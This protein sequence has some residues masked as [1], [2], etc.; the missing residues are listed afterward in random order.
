MN[1]RTPIWAFIAVVIGFILLAVLITPHHT[2]EQALSIP[3]SVV[4]IEN[5]VFPGSSVYGYVNED[6]ELIEFPTCSAAFLGVSYS[7]ESE[8]GDYLFEWVENSKGGGVI[9]ASLT[10]RGTK[11]ALRCNADGAVFLLYM[12]VCIPQK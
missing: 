7:C 3:N 5:G 11:I 8:N 10:V 4:E 12:A 1:R 9:S 6:K 2:K